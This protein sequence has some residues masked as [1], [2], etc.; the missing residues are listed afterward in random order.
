MG[1]RPRHEPERGAPSHGAAVWTRNHDVDVA[2]PGGPDGATDPNRRLL[3]VEF[4]TRLDATQSEV[5][6][7]SAPESIS[8][9]YESIDL[10]GMTGRKMNPAGL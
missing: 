8:A 1:V 2:E 10:T 9:S 3:I 5:R 6:M 7:F 4:Q